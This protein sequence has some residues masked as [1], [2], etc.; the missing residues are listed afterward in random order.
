MLV[1]FLNVGFSDKNTVILENVSFR[2]EEGQVI[3]VIGPNGGGKTTLTKLLLGILKPTSGKIIKNKNL[4]IGYMPQKMIINSFLP[5]TVF[6][7]LGENTL[8]E[9]I[10]DRKLSSLSCGELQK[11]LLERCLLKNP[12]L[13]I[14]DE[15]I[16]GADVNSQEEFYKR[17]KDFKGTVLMISH[18]LNFVF[19]SSDMVFCLN[20]HMCCKGHPTDLKMSDA[21]KNFGFYKHHHDECSHVL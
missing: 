15:P 16:Q 4:V 20:K 10:K 12:N 14:L 11:V 7:F 9:S 5:I 6:E 3:T 1:E 21:Y 19:K 2:V 17:I 8:L 18:D 13:L